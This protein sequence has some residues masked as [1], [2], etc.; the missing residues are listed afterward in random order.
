MS[1]LPK[2]QGIE[3]ASK[4]ER[5]EQEL[6]EVLETSK[7]MDME[8]PRP[9]EETVQSRDIKG[10]RTEQTKEQE[11][12]EVLKKLPSDK[13]IATLAKA[14]AAKAEKRKALKNVPV[15]GSPAPNPFDEVHSLL[16]Q[17]KSQWQLTHDMVQDLQKRL[18]AETPL[19]NQQVFAATPVV[20][21]TTISNPADVQNVQDTKALPYP[22]INS[23]GMKRQRVPDDLDDDEDEDFMRKMERY[24]KRN[25]RAL[26][27]VL[28]HNPRME[29]RAK[30]DPINS[31]VE[32]S[33]SSSALFW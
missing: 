33:S 10:D 24:R 31:G 7:D 8:T 4:T 22:A 29:E 26:D 21:K 32:S 9:V 20:P 25:K 2:L 27:E 3:D 11:A 5:A 14:R 15:E 6:D 18:P 16:H 13:Q 1:D 12:K 28:Y 17:M 23:S 30:Q 19:Q